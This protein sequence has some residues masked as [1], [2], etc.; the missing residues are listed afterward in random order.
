MKK[1][2]ELVAAAEKMAEAYKNWVVS[3]AA[4]NNL[5]AKRG[6][7]AQFSITWDKTFDIK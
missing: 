7:N 4:Y 3:N 1:K 6:T 5:L 2:D